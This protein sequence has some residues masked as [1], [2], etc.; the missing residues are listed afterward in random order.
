MEFTNEQIK[1]DSIPTIDHI[2]FE[3]LDIKYRKSQLISASL[4]YIGIIAVIILAYLFFAEAKI[5]GIWIVLVVALWFVL[6]AITLWYVWESYEFEGFALR[7]KDILYKSGIFFQSVLIIPFNRVQ[8]SEI[9]QGP[10]ERLFNLGSL[11]LYTAGGSSSDLA[12]HGLAYPKAQLIK[13]TIT[14]RIIADGEE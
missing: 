6:F 5:S 2:G 7:E 14:K 1:V 12:I 3:V 8:H 4:F 10:I 11:I 13:E 9:K